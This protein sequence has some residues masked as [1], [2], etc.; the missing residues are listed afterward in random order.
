[1]LAER[2]FREILKIVNEKEDRYSSGTDCFVRD[3]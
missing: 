3:F 2:D 1:M